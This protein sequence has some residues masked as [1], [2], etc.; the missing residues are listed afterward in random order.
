M[1]TLDL[2]PR[3]ARRSDV[4]CCDPGFFL[5]KVYT[6]TVLESPERYKLLIPHINHQELFSTVKDPRFVLKDAY[7]CHPAEITRTID[8]I[9]N[10]EQVVTSAMHVFVTCLVYGVPCA[11]VKPENS[12]M[13]PGDGVKYLDCMSTVLP[14]DFAPQVI[15]VRK[16]M[17]LLDEVEI[18]R[19]V[20]DENHV[21]LSYNRFC[22]LLQVGLQ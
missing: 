1:V 7:A 20:I 13:I 21:E 9:Y 22:E 18:K 3:E 15:N 19:H 2:L 12:D 6:P 8:L 10:A 14:Y 5:K 17:A 4:V 16:G 11:L